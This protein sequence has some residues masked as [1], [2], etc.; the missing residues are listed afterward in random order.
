MELIDF[1][2]AGEKLSTKG[3]VVCNFGG[4]DMESV[5]LGNN[6]TF[7]TTRDNNSSEQRKVSTEYDS[8][9]PDVIQIMKYN[10]NTST[11]TPFTMDEIRDIMMWLNRKSYKKFR[12]IYDNNVYNGVF[13]YGSFNIQE[14]VIDG[15]IIG[16]ELTF[17]TNAPYGFAETVTK[18]S[19]IAANGTVTIDTDSDEEGKL[20]PD[21]TILCSK[22][23]DLTIENNRDTTGKTIIKNCVAGEV[24][25]FDGK[26]RQIS[27]SKSGSNHMTLPVDYNYHVPRLITERGADTNTFKFSIACS[28][29]IQFNPIRKVGI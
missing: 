28:V 24:I 17:V 21:V 12:P 10:C 23:G 11:C 5:S 1:E 16:L 9:A 8:Y 25:K 27:S 14:K 4:S 18:Q 26:T 29:T 22:S 15:N 7:N 3:C 6:L 13:Y 20:Y 2:Y 19:T